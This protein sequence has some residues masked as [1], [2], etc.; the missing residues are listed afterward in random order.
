MV[1]MRFWIFG[2]PDERVSRAGGERKPGEEREA[3]PL[4]EIHDVVPRPVGDVVAVLHRH[5]RDD[6]LG[7][8]D[9]RDADLGQADVPH[10]SLAHELGEDAELLVGGNV[11]VDSVKLPEVDA[12]EL[13]PLRLPS[14]ARR[15]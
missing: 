4:A 10:L 14:S 8:L 3:V 15:R 11:L 9:L 5:D 7:L 6:T 12:V 13:E 1:S 2:A